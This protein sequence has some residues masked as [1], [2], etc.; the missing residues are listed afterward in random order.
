MSIKSHVIFILQHRNSGH[1]Y[2]TILDASVQPEDADPLHLGTNSVPE[3]APSL[4]AVI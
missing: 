4:L 2:C 3:N 1:F